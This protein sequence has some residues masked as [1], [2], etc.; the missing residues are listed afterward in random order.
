MM[1]N[2]Q[3]EYEESDQNSFDPVV[4]CAWLPDTEL[5]MSEYLD[6]VSYYVQ[7]Y[8]EKNSNALPLCT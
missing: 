5:K 4:D 6:M 3:N 7:N 1:K 2:I 8:I